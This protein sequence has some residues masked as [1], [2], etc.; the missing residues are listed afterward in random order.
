MI[1]SLKDYY[2][3]KRIRRILSFFHEIQPSAY[4]IKPK[5]RF[6]SRDAWV[7]FILVIFLLLSLGRFMSFLIAAFIAVEISDYIMIRGTKFF[8][9]IFDY[10]LPLGFLL[11]IA[12]LYVGFRHFNLSDKISE[13]HKKKN[14]QLHSMPVKN[15]SSVG[16]GENWSIEKFKNGT[17]I[18]MSREEA[19][20]ACQNRGSILYT[21][22]FFNFTPPLVL[23]RRAYFWVG[24]SGGQLGPGVVSKP[25]VYIRVNTEPMHLALC[26]K[27]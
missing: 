24:Q 22:D 11:S 12:V 20:L 8:D 1:D 19:I 3:E 26:V 2:R 15:I 25:S 9:A 18:P 7:Q 5:I 21:G 10:I 17:A 6:I 16:S 27:P 23:N 13:F 14:R 4:D